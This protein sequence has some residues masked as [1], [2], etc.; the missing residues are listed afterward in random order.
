MTRLNVFL[1]AITLA[2]FRTHKIDT[3]IV[4]IFNTYGPRMR[5]HDGRAIPE[6]IDQ[7]LVNKP[8][9]AFGNGKQTRSFGYIDDLVE[10][11]VKLM[12]SKLN[13]PVNIGNPNEMSINALASMIIKLIGSTSKITYKK[14]PVDDPK[15]RKP[16]I[17]LAK[18]ELKWL[19]KVEVKEG[20]K[21]TIEYF[22]S[23]K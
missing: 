5:P 19:P 13:T 10:G 6:F 3:K 4:R 16:D 9:T 7:A 12:K 11:L 14:L 23:L 20:L 18:K 1:K 17:T 8:I 22:K 2:Y 15:V 21:R